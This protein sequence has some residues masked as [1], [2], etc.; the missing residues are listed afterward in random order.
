LERPCLISKT[1]RPATR[2][3]LEKKLSNRSAAT[4]Q[5]CTYEQT[6]KQGRKRLNWDYL[7][8]IN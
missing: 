2:L 8:L 1:R 5:V 3:A 6:E 4:V 7:K